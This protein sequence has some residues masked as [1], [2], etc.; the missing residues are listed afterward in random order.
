M[1]VHMYISTYIY[2]HVKY[3]RWLKRIHAC[4]NYSVV[5]TYVH[6]YIHTYLHMH[7]NK[8]HTYIHTYT[9]TDIH[10]YIHVH[11]HIHIHIHIRVT[12]A[13]KKSVHSGF[14]YYF[15][16]CCRVSPCCNPVFHLSCFLV[17]SRFRP[18]VV[19]FLLSCYS[20]FV[21]SFIMS[22]LCRS[23]ISN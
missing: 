6:T 5:H 16:Y 14:P 12:N 8:K 21:P 19:P 17:F 13:C 1:C 3:F 22:C 11:I 18:F 7:T 23:A 10:T 2:I 4:M 9:H 20:S 15:H